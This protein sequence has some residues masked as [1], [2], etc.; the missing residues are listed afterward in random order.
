MKLG[1]VRAI[2]SKKIVPCK[3]L[4]PYYIWKKKNMKPFF[5][6]VESNRC[7]ATNTVLFALPPLVCES[8]DQI[9]CQ[10]LTNERWKKAS[11]K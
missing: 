8:T 5:C 3:I 6:L 2:T 7:C 10:I 11:Q 9:V 4:M 1:S